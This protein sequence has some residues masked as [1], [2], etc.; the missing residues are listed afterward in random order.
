VLSDEKQ[1]ASRAMSQFLSN[2]NGRRIA[3]PVLTSILVGLT[4][5]QTAGACVPELDGLGHLLRQP[6]TFRPLGKARQFVA[7]NWKLIVRLANAVL[8]LRTVSTGQIAWLIDS[9]P[10]RRAA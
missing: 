8:E 2:E 6:A 10:L 7:S 4:A 9:Q 5:V 3:E 1:I